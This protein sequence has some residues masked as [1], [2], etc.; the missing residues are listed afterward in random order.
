MAGKKGL[1]VTGAAMTKLRECYA[2]A[3]QHEGYG[4]GRFVRKILEEAEMNLANRMVL[5]DE[6]EL[7]TGL[8]TTV[9]ECDIPEIGFE[10]KK[11]G[12]RIGFAC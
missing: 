3:R 11:A 6:S 5:L 8:I 2:A 10:E 1:T 12:R 9:E 7:S 4:N